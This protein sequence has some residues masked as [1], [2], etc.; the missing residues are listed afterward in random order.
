MNKLT[1]LEFT[2]RAKIIH[3]ESYLYPEQAFINT[4]T[5]IKIFCKRLKAL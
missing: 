2:K 4:K 3:N 1:F 5:K